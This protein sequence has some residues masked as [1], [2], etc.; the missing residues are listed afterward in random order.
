MV[1]YGLHDID[2]WGP[3]WTVQVKAKN[4]DYFKMAKRDDPIVSSRCHFSKTLS[5]T[6][7]TL[8]NQKSYYL[9]PAPKI[10][11]LP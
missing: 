9:I 6:S 7:F 1:Y 8:E 3:G 2:L 10:G 5:T 11:Y 4:Q